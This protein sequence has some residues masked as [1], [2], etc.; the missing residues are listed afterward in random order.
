MSDFVISAR[1]RRQRQEF[2]SFFFLNKA[3]EDLSLAARELDLGCE[4]A[5]AGVAHQLKG[6]GATLGFPEVTARASRILR[7]L[8]ESPKSVVRDSVTHLQ[9]VIELRLQDLDY[10]SEEVN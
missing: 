10:V 9:R 6:A 3:R 1:E 7:Q 4:E 5:V 8:D 2:L